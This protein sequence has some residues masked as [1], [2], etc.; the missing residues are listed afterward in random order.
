RFPKQ[1]P[2]ELA[3]PAKTKEIKALIGVDDLR[4]VLVEGRAPGSQPRRQPRLDLPRLLLAVT[5][6]H[7]IVSI[8]DHR[9][10][11][12]PEIARTNT[13]REIANPGRLF[14]PVQRDIHEQR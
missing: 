2:A 14:Q 11:S 4:F 6:R 13:A 3:A 7:K 1:P 10:R 8:A 9:R 5:E 12:G